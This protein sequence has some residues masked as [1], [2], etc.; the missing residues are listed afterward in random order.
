MEIIYLKNIR[1]KST[2]GNVIVRG[3]E[4]R[5]F[6]IAVFLFCLTGMFHSTDG[7]CQSLIGY[8]HSLHAGIAGASTNPASLA[9]N[10]FSMDIMP[11]G[12]SFEV[13]NN[14][15]GI[16]RADVRLPGFGAKY[17]HLHNRDTKKAAFFRGEVLLPAI[18]FSN[19]NFGW[20]VDLKMRT[21]F[22]AD[23]IERELA[24]FL[25]YSLNDPPNFNMD[26][27]NRHIGINA[28]SW[29]EIGGTYART[30]TSSAE[31]FFSVGVRPKL[32]LGAGAMYAF[33]NDAGY[34]FSSDT[35]LAFIGGDI[36]F[37]HSKNFAFDEGYRMSYT[38]GFNPGI[39][40]DIG[41][42]Y[43]Y[44]PDAL[45]ATAREE[46]VWPGYRNRAA[47]KYRVSVALTDLGIIRFR[48]GELSDAYTI[49]A[50]NWVLNGPI[51]NATSPAAMYETF[52]ERSGGSLQNKPFW[53]RLPLALNASVDYLI[54]NH[55]Y[56]NATAF[57]AVYLRNSN[58]K[59][60]HE[61]TRLSITPRYERRW[62]A[63]WA[64]LSFSRMGITSLGAGVRVGPLA[65][66]TGD[67]LNL[68]L[69]RKT[70]YNADAYVV[71]KVPLFPWPFARNPNKT[72]TGDKI[73]ECAE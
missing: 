56:V 27:T 62:F 69:K 28:M 26:L 2:A 47:Y 61:L 44:R 73:D 33:I 15:I 49:S 13:A 39:G 58:S 14:Y 32:L 34:T 51:F 41:M 12:A 30:I 40:L 38:F 55:F 25:A 64:P 35:M 57:A 1:I 21:Y 23:G 5:C 52:T 20:G 70:I 31:T 42:I 54:A 10:A 66:G 68:L 37:G 9:D 45:Q 46:K 60:V 19:E 48:H 17:F 71:L 29:L 16:Q 67:I 11:G 50:D 22:N 4:T 59:R 24:H 3:R 18:M 63:V 36:K 8:N 7:R 43:E 53:M 65:I 6:P 72:R